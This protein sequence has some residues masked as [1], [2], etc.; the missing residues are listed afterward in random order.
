MLNRFII[1]FICNIF[2]VPGFANLIIDMDKYKYSVTLEGSVTVSEFYWAVGCGNNTACNGG[3]H[4]FGP[5]IFVKVVDAQGKD[6]SIIYANNNYPTCNQHYPESTRYWSNA[7]KSSFV[8]WVNSYL[9]S[10]PVYHLYQATD[11]PPSTIQSYQ[12]MAVY[13]RCKSPQNGVALHT[14]LYPETVTIINPPPIVGTCSLN[15]QN[16]NLNYSSNSLNVN[17]ITQ[18][19]DLNISCTS[20]DANDYQLKL[21]GTDVTKGRLNFGNGVSAQISINGTQV[22]ANG[23]GIQLN[24]LTSR[25]IPIIATLVGTAS[26]SGITNA[27]GILVLDAL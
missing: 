2:M 11:I 26:S 20:G 12:L 18:S 24:S 3:Q 22:Q 7:E 25:S 23:L 1:F 21:I 13:F 10:S 14:Q 9:S 15:S 4:E 6:A 8:Q 27:N 17:S 19:T 5:A 16:L